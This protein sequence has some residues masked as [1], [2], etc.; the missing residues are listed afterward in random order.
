MKFDARDA[1]RL[2]S[3]RRRQRVNDVALALSLLAMA[4][5]V[6][7]LLW[8]LF[9]TLRQGLGG[10]ALS[11]FTE[12][13]P[14][15]LQEDG[16]LANAIW[17]S[18]LMVT[19]AT[20]IGTPVGI[21]AGIYLAEYGQ[22]GW[23]GSAV[24]FINDILLS[25]PSIV[26]GL[27]I[28]AVV[29]APLRGFSGWAG[30]LAL[31]LIVIPVVIRTTEN[32]L[33]LIPNALREAA[34]ALGAPEW[35]V[36]ASVTLR[37]ARAGVVTGV[38]LALAR[39][40]GETAPLLFTALSNQFWTSDLGEPMASLPVTIFKFAMSPY[41]NWQQLAW[42]GV[43]LITLGVLVLNIVARVLLRNRD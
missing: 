14:P 39:I 32:M 22:R 35:K 18:L 13:T 43:F 4:F 11:L 30:V 19:L 37:A 38:L 17:G 21:F 8:I 28:Y 26:I 33:A 16:G 20:L 3:L 23:L 41:E 2:A 1:S 5:G 42:A 29:V 36:V 25:A 34:Y 15:P 40:S 7:W 31:A 24:R 6:F 27:F 10:M 12:M 9:E